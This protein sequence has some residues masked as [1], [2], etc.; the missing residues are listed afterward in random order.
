M[1]IW[2]A[3]PGHSGGASQGQDHRR[4]QPKLEDIKEKIPRDIQQGS[5]TE[6]MIHVFC[7]KC[8]SPRKDFFRGFLGVLRILSLSKMLKN[9]NNMRGKVK[10]YPGHPQRYRKK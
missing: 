5:A 2:T 7:D 8:R 4:P 10:A 9:P 6:M 1:T 3:P